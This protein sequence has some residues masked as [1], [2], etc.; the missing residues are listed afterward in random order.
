M[1]DHILTH[2]TSYVTQFNMD[3]PSD[4]IDIVLQQVAKRIGALMKGDVT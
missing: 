1:S 3:Q 2:I 4:D